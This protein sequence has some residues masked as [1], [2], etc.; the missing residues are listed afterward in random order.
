MTGYHISK[1]YTI[2]T[3][4]RFGD[5]TK[6]LVGTLFTSPPKHLD[7][8]QRFQV[9]CRELRRYDLPCPN[10]IDQKSNGANP[11][12]TEADRESWIRKNFETFP[13]TSEVNDKDIRIIVG[14]MKSAGTVR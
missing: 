3:I 6:S 12:S 9:I 2:L 8:K 4:W 1:N 11:H 14:A 7:R 10:F 13:K 5:R